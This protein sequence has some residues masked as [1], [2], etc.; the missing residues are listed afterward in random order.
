MSMED[1]M[2]QVFN[3]YSQLILGN[4]SSLERSAVVNKQLCYSVASLTVGS[5]GENCLPADWQYLPLLTVLNRR[6]LP[7][8]YALFLKT[9]RLVYLLDWNRVGLMVMNSPNETVYQLV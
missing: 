4:G 2:P 1:A 5:N 9:T 6:M 8:R 3:L 7:S